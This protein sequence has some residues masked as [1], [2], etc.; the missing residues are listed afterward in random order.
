MLLCEWHVLFT[1]LVFFPHE[2]IS[3]FV[4]GSIVQCARTRFALIP[5]ETMS[6]FVIGSIVLFTCFV[7]I[8]D[9]TVCAFVIG[10][11]V[12]CARTRF[13]LIPD[14]TVGALVIGNVVLC[15]RTRFSP[16][17]TRVLSQWYAIRTDLAVH[18]HIIKLRDRG[19]LQCK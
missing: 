8:P 14:E 18:N 5:D 2:T 13:A 6:A 17:L 11:I 3:V 4:I 1:R 15:E 9:E 10:S 19:Q 7:L 12:Q 16:F